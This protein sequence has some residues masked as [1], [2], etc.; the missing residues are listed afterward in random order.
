[1]AEDEQ[2][3]FRRVFDWT[4]VE[5]NLLRKLLVVRY[6]EDPEGPLRDLQQPRRFDRTN[7]LPCSGSS[8]TAH[9]RIPPSGLSA[10]ALDTSAL[11]ARARRGIP[12]ERSAVVRGSLGKSSNRTWAPKPER[13]SSTSGGLGISIGN[14]PRLNGSPKRSTWRSGHYYE[15]DR[16]S[17]ASGRPDQGPA[18]SSCRWTGLATFARDLKRYS[19]SPSKSCLSISGNG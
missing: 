8:M 2:K 12:C 9:P 19:D 15:I 3:K 1:M 14:S 13:C 6:G 5:E 18:M 10:S 7:S 4:S 16:P 11:S 17:T